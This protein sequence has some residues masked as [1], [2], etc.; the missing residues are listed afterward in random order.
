[1]WCVFIGRTVLLFVITGCQSNNI[2]EVEHL[3]Y[4]LKLFLLGK[5]V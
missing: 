1:M 3:I 5:N 2:E 4:R